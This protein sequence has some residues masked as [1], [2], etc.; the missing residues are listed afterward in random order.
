VYLRFVCP[1]RT[2]K[3]NQ[4]V[5]LRVCICIFRVRVDTDSNKA[6]IPKNLK[7]QI[8]LIHVFK[9]GGDKFSEI[10]LCGKRGVNLE[11]GDPDVECLWI[12]CHY[13]IYVNRKLGP[14]ST[15]R[16]IWSNTSQ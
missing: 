13:F 14:I 2:R 7:A 10:Q 4:K 9:G 1:Q 8:C 16:P 3:T 6:K 15:A 11:K 12:R 5:T